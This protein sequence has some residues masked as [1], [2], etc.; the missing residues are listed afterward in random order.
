MSLGPENK[1]TGTCVRGGSDGEKG[2]RGAGA[3][4]GGGSSNEEKGD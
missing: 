3:C 2:D 4:V 1:Q